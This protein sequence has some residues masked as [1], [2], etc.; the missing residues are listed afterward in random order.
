VGTAIG[1]TPPW[2]FLRVRIFFDLAPVVGLIL[3]ALLAFRR[4]PVSLALYTIGMIALLVTSAVPLDYDPFNAEGRYVL[5][6]IP[7]FL[8]LGRWMVRRPWLE[9]L[10]VGGGFMLQALFLGFFLRGGWLV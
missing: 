6:V 4:W 10:L 7:L 8:L 1:N 3:V 2:S 9:M 5:L